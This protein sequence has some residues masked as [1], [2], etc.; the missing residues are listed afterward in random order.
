MPNA[1]RVLMQYRPGYPQT[2]TAI[3]EEI[4]IDVSKRVDYQSVQWEQ[5][6]TEQNT[7]F[8][9][10]IFTMLSLSTTRYDDYTS[11]VVSG[12]GLDA[13]TNVSLGMV[14][15]INDPSFFID[16]ANRTEVKVQEWGLVDGH[17][18]VIRTL[19]GGVVSSVDT[20]RQGDAFIVQRVECADYT[21]LLDELVIR[22]YNAPNVSAALA[23]RPTISGLTTEVVAGGLTLGAGPYTFRVVAYGSSDQILEI[24]THVSQNLTETDI[25]PPGISDP[26]LRTIKLDWTSVAGA[27]YYKV[28]AK[29]G[30]G[31]KEMY[32]KAT[33][34]NPAVTYSLSTAPS[35]T[36]ELSPESK[37]QK[38]SI[39]LDIISG[40]SDPENFN[41]KGIFNALDPNLNPGIN[42]QSAY[43]ETA[44]KLNDGTPDPEKSYRFSPTLDTGIVLTSPFGGKTLKQALNIVIEKTGGV[45]WVDANKDLHYTNKQARELVENPRFESSPASSGYS[46]AGGHSILQDRGPYG[47]G[48]ALVASSGATTAESQISPVPVTANQYYFARVQGWA[49]SNFASDW[50]A[51]LRFYDDLS[52]THQVGN[53]HKLQRNIAFDSTDDGRWCKTWVMAQAHSTAVTAR[54]VFNKKRNG[55]DEVAWTDFSL[56]KITGTI[57]FSDQPSETAY[58]LPMK[59]FETPK[60]PRS[61]AKVANRL[62]VYGVYKDAKNPSELES[63][64]TDISLTLK[65]IAAGSLAAGKYYVR[66]VAT[67]GDVD[68]ICK[69]A[70][71]TITDQDVIDGNRELYASWAAVSGATS[72]KIYVGSKRFAMRLKATQAGTTLSIQ[73]PAP[74]G[75]AISVE[76]NV[77]YY[78]VFD[79]APGIWE[80]G[81][82]ILEAAINDSLVD[83]DEKASTRALAFWE[84]KG[85][86][87]RTWEF[88]T[89]EQDVPMVGEV[90]PFVWVADDT[91]EPLMVKG[92][93]ARI[94]GDRIYYT[95]IVGD[96]PLLTKRGV[97]QIFSD[98]QAAT[99][100]LNDTISPE[101][102]QS[103]AVTAPVEALLQTPDGVTRASVTA[104]WVP[105]PE[106]DFAHY[107]VEYGYDSAFTEVQ[108]ANVSQTSDS[109]SASTGVK[110]NVVHTFQ[111]EPGKTLYY[112]VAAIDK[113]N[114]KSPWSS[115]EIEIPQ[116][117]TPC[118]PPYNAL[119]S[120]GL[121]SN[122]VTWQF[123]FYNPEFPLANRNNTDFARFRVYRR[124]H[125]TGA[126]AVIAE[127]SATQYVDTDFANYSAGYNYAVTSLD[128]T[129]NESG[130]PGSGGAT[131]VAYNTTSSV[132]SK[133]DGGVDITTA[134]ISGAQIAS[135]TI[136]DANV[137]SLSATKITAGTLNI[138]TGMTIVSDGTATAPQFEVDKDGVTIRDDSGNIVL[139]VNGST[140][141]LNADYIDVNGLT[142]T[143][144]TV[145]TGNGVVRVGNYP[146]STSPTFQG[147]W[148]GNANPSSAAFTLNTSGILTATSA[149]ISGSVSASSGAI[150]GWAI[151]SDKIYKATAVSPYITGIYTGTS[152]SSGLTFFAGAA[153]STGTSAAFSVTNAGAVTATNAN[154]TGTIS[155]SAGQIG[156]F[157]I[158]ATSLTAGSG[159]TAVGISPASYPFFAGS[160]TASTAPFSVTSAGVLTAT[161]A[162]ITGSVTANSGAIGGWTLSS[163]SLTGGNTTISSAGDI[164][165]GTGAN[166]ARLSSSDAAYRLWL[167][168]T[169]ASTA[170][171]RV[172]STGAVTATDAN[173][174]GTISASAG[175]IGG[176][177][178]GAT[179]LTAGS[180]ATAVGI[181]PASYPFFA[182]SS[183][184]STAPFSVT[185]AGVLT[186]TSASI[187]GSVTANSGTVGGWT[188]SSTSLTAGSGESAVGIATSGGY[189]FYAGNSTASSAEFRVTPEGLLTATSASITGSVTANSGAIG[190]WSLTSTSLSGGNTTISSTGDI[191]L[192]TGAN[193]ARLSSSDAVYRLWLGSTTAST[194]P[195]RVTSTGSVTATDANITGTISASAGQ[196]GGFTI[197]A[198]SLTAGSGATAVGISPTS[199]PFFAGSSTASTAPFNVTSAGVLTATS[200]SITGAVTATS[201]S[202]GGW[203]LSSTSL[204]GGNTT[205][206]STGDITVGS[207]ANIARL[208]SS[209]PAYRL[210]L[211]G[212]TASTAPFRV[213]S[214]GSFVATSANVTGTI[215]TSNITATGGTVGG[216][217]LSSSSLIAG[218]GV[219][220]VGINATGAGPTIFAGSSSGPSAP[221]QVS[222]NG[223]V[224][225]KN[226][227]VLGGQVLI[228]EIG[229]EITEISLAATTGIVTV[230]TTAA[231]D[232]DKYSVGAKI[233]IDVTGTYASAAWANGYFIIAS[234]GASTLTYQSEDLVS[235]PL[236]D[237]SAGGF[238]YLGSQMAVG[239]DG[240]SAAAWMTVEGNKF[241][242]RNPADPLVT[243]IEATAGAVT[244]NADFINA[245]SL[246][247]GDLD[248]N[249]LTTTNFSVTNAGVVTA[250]TGN[251]VSVISPTDATYRLWIGH[252]TGAAAPFSV[253]STGAISATSGSV[254]GWTLSSTSFTGGNTTISSAGDITLGTGSNVA[255]LSSSD[256]AYRLW[257]GGS[258]AS[259]APFRVT[260]TG[261]FTATDANIT[262]AVSASSGQIGGFTIGATSLTAGSG[263]TA[264][265]IVPASFPFFAGSSTASTAPFRVTSAG[266]LTATDASITGAITTANITATGGT[267][268]GW[269]LSSTSFTGGNTTIASAGD[270]TLGTGENV[271]RLSSSDAA[272]RLWLGGSTASTAPFRVTSTGALTATGVDITGAVSASSGQI[273][274][275][276]IGATSLTAGSGATAV[277][278][279]PASF[280]FFA[281]SSTA[282]TAPF[283]VTSTGSLTATSAN[284]TGTISTSNITATGGTI[285]GWNLSSTSL[286]SSNTTISSTGDITLGTGENVARLSSSDAAYR[287]WLGGSTASTA[288]F[289]VTSTGVM[290]ATSATITGSVTAT[291]GSIGGWSVD[292]SRIYNALAS[293]PYIAGVQGSST[294]TGVAFFAGGTS[295]TGATAAFKV[296]NDGALTATSASITGVVTATSGSFTGTISASAGQIGGWAISSDRITNLGATKYAGIIDT[297]TDNGLAFFAGA[298]STA[299]TGAVFSVTNE[300]ALTATSASVTGTISTNNIT[301]TGGFIGGWSLSSTSLTGGN[302]TIASAGDITLGTGENVARLS[303]SDAAYRLWL[304]GSTA[305]TAPFRVT[306]TG[307]MTAT[308]ASITGTVSTNN[309][310]ATGGFIGGW[311]LTSTSLTNY[312]G[313]TGQYAGILDT[314]STGLAFFSGATTSTGT[315][316]Q[317]S[318]TNAGALTAT[319]ATISGAITATSGAIGG[320]SVG[321]DKIYNSGVSKFIGLVDAAADED[322]A[323]FAG[324]TNSTGSGATFT[325]TNAGAVTASSGTIAGWS[326]ASDRIWSGSG[327]SY[328]GMSTGATSFFAGANTSSGATALFS[329]TNAGALAATNATLSSVTVNPASKPA[330]MLQGAKNEGDI[331]VPS[332]STAT[333]T[334]YTRTTAE[335]TL[336][337]SANHNFAAG[338]S[339]TITGSSVTAFNSTFVITAVTANTFTFV[340]AGT[341]VVT[342]T[343]SGGTASSSSAISFGV[344]NTSTFAYT[345]GM[346]YLPKD[347]DNASRLTIYGSDGSASR[348]GSLRLAR[349]DGSVSGAT[350]GT[351]SYNGSSLTFASPLSVTGGVVS[352]GAIQSTSGSIESGVNG[353][354]RGSFLARGDGTNG[355]YI[356]LYSGVGSAGGTLSYDVANGRFNMNN[357]LY[358]SGALEASLSFIAGTS[359]YAGG[360]GGTGNM[361]AGFLNMGD[362]PGTANTADR[363]GISLAGSNTSGYAIFSRA[364]AAQ[365]DSAIWAQADFFSGT[366]SGIQFRRMITSGAVYSNT[367]VINVAASTTTAP[368]FASGSDYRMK[369]NIREASSEID[370]LDK[371]IS[372]K[373]VIFDNAVDP[374]S[375]LKYNQIGFI[376]H[377][378]QSIIPQAV[379]GDKDAVDAAGNPIYQNLSDARFIPYLVGAIKELA[380]QNTAL[381]A[382]IAALE[383]A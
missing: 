296:T 333:I 110:A 334:T 201:G 277:G 321:L 292:S 344:Y 65:K 145:G 367:G 89:F 32:Y 338:A 379:T 180:G 377:E 323:I 260:S 1:I 117:I 178:I 4:W 106:D 218:S 209:D 148:G 314:D 121:K 161:S 109:Q 189:A 182:G 383:G 273:G 27:T 310:T 301:A 235:G 356:A 197:G 123:Y 238:I 99:A 172:T 177:T 253:T 28:F 55:G 146:N 127:T 221:F 252:S 39:D 43:I 286:T 283:R 364:A 317:F 373:P 187:T 142:A 349:G 282:S 305:S 363:Q 165:L 246:N 72:Y 24:F 62:L 206:S 208:S 242:L 15:A 88:D 324:A 141:T 308:S 270:I 164:T 225:A 327:S 299:G 79:F 239:G 16:I 108:R 71:E 19:W 319:G 294:S 194:A 51:E 365:T 61:A 37:V 158:G 76:P 3:Q 230:T 200:A 262:G 120:P 130:T 23:E 291:S 31:V 196:I 318:V 11:W 245:G 231:Y 171:F 66:V 325:V 132:P 151:D 115:D 101:A 278:I 213:T 100:R 60:A 6:A 347:S 183:T 104:Q 369:T 129:G 274:G 167:G 352:S 53:G 80:S 227:T 339:V 368:S 114:N 105:S 17:Y 247:I 224:Q 163:T 68:I 359:I 118:D 217:T 330:L 300:G 154:I 87:E 50:E 137:G 336:T 267:V 269:T 255:R 264:V 33:V 41:Y 288:P 316:A 190:G 42:N 175:Q 134:S 302:T 326:I 293:S 85:I 257:L 279:I 93:K 126:Y 258:T 9:F 48:R 205:I 350:Y 131:G 46:L 215:S 236:S 268:G 12:N 232:T 251:N 74:G 112:R 241:A 54:I 223:A 21:A 170:P 280:P 237:A 371:I 30:V 111:A 332:S 119:V 361:Y 202:I 94:F 20:E 222:N 271:A 153:T 64:E 83:N 149:S 25:D 216:W 58:A 98:M 162:S 309:I 95:V 298:T 266:S 228:G 49:K 125:N 147:I 357:D 254:G 204:T 203:S 144:I 160:S 150:G 102:P 168:G 174:T 265:G 133:I 382:R 195:F 229:P 135:A 375:P 355:G 289:R 155:A 372:L 70:T 249:A 90:I 313:S 343:S 97:T 69:Y 35:V 320:W 378:V 348:Y 315:G 220:S 290:T 92:V 59:A 380:Q 22:D 287:L 73:T 259:T 345:R 57:G 78:K 29:A 210:W 303:S 376:A 192:G 211:G 342:P 75:A 176:F 244:I 143:E 156:G 329:V 370:M 14:D 297:A 248:T 63:V 7:A 374:E 82:K 186:A 188:L 335:V 311:S 341:A 198:T 44:K 219:N 91:A 306:S 275:F 207:G 234:T 13:H 184:A 233:L 358:V 124:V 103:L 312:G 128:R 240:G 40:S 381:E 84:E 166:V 263:A 362:D 331:A 328:V 139:Q 276:T 122:T 86:A 181:S 360:S 10:D 47:Y 173:I 354:T 96:D 256:P 307:V 250:G 136:T 185:S 351:I 179:S 295:S 152:A 199:Y 337:T 18:E 38:G 281:G 116:D 2:S 36:G 26:A 261:S 5:Q 191:T 284:I 353:T 285:G 45:F 159:A 107:A 157:T 113:T 67:V 138:S 304:G 214:T 34:A 366:W 243:V 226:I 52:A 346:D 8:R 81:G 340:L 56:V 272:Y 169:T 212:T 77:Y 140:A 193:V 322:I